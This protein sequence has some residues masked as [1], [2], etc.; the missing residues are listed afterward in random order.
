MQPYFNYCCEVWNVFGE[1]QPIRLQKFHNRAARI[2]ANLPNEV[3]QQTALDALGWEPLKEQRK[4][5]KAKIMFKILN[6]MG[7]KCLNDLFTF[8]KEVLNHNLRDSSTTVCLPQP[9]TNNMKKSLMFD[10]ASIWNSLPANIRES[11]S[12]PCFQRKIATYVSH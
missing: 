12:L 10:G 4:K 7:P 6:D 11:K 2:I 3:D 9:R 5:A 1:T 8:K